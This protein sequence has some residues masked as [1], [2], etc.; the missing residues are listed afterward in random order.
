MK[1]KLIVSSTFAIVLTLFIIAIV[2][3]FKK[4]RFMAQGSMYSWD[5]ETIFA[6]KEKFDRITSEYDIEFLYQDFSKEYLETADDSF[7]EDMNERGIKV[8]HLNG[9]PSWGADNGYKRIAKEIDLVANFNEKNDHK[10]EG[11][12]LDIEPYASETEEKFDR[13][14]F[15]TYVEQIEKSYEYCKD[16]DLE[17]FLAIPYWFDSI[18]K[19]MLEKLIKNSDGVSVMN[20][21]ID[22]TIKD[23]TT[24]IELAKKYGK[25]IDTI[26]EIKF[27][28]RDRFPNREA[29]LEDYKTLKEHF[30]YDLLR[31]SYHHYEDI[32]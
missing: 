5:L 13:S 22:D 16:K 20:Y 8:Y 23:I 26:Y 32:D 19:S 27:D 24:E 6:D 14:A 30:A 4:D 21:H 2:S 7:I 25:K 15:K 12:V 9:D 31:I 10:L 28:R 3:F 11:I 1:K 18:S 17:F 29:I